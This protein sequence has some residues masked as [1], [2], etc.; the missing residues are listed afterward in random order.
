MTRDEIIADLSN[1]IVK[2]V[3]RGEEP[4]CPLTADTL[5]FDEN[6]L[7]LDSLD[8]VEIVMI[9]E[10]YYHAAINDAEKAREICATLS[11]LADFIIESGH[12]VE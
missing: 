3:L 6:G 4:E 11:S 7:G 5:L 1:R 10:K 9:M 2:D 8:A 12:P